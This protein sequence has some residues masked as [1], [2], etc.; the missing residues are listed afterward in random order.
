MQSF[1][2]ES[3]SVVSPVKIIFILLGERRANVECAKEQRKSAYRHRKTD[4]NW[5][6]RESV[7]HVFHYSSS[8]HK[9]S[10]CID[11][12]HKGHRCTPNKG[13]RWTPTEVIDRPQQR[14]SIDRNTEVIDRPQQRGH[15]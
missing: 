5:P 1:I 11:L 10:V 3:V 14:S 9:F 7:S 2:G 4:L 8:S 12:A 6:N 13:H 15:R